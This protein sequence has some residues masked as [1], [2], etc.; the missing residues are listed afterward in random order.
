[1]VPDSIANECTNIKNFEIIFIMQYCPMCSKEY[2]DIAK[3]CPLEHCPNCGSVDIQKQKSRRRKSDTGERIFFF[4]F[5]FGAIAL[6]S[7]GIAQYY[8]VIYHSISIPL[9]IVMIL[10]AYHNSSIQ[11]FYCKSCM[12]KKFT[13]IFNIKLK[14]TRKTTEVDNDIEY[15]DKDG[16]M[17]KIDSF[18]AIQTK[19]HKRDL[20]L[21]LIGITVSASLGS[22]GLVMNQ[23][24]ITIFLTEFFSEK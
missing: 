2:N 11:N 4:S 6:L 13:H 1:M 23:E 8:G 19:H 24:G 22:I 15:Q 12:A 16:I 7:L 9:V 21:K 14:K 3:T 10:T 20:I 5:G 17:K 18:S